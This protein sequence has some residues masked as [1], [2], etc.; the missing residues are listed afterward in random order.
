MRALLTGGG[1]LCFG[2]AAAWL[3]IAA[4]QN[5]F[6]GTVFWAAFMQDRWDRSASRE[7][8][9]DHWHDVKGPIVLVVF[10]AALLLA[11]TRL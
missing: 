9:S 2:L 5:G 6:L 1:F 8:L 7:L 3:L 4:Y 11:G 10:G